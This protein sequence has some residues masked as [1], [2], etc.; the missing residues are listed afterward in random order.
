M[1]A[2]SPSLMFVV[3][4]LAIGL[5]LPTAAL[6][7]CDTL[8]GPVVTA[9]RKALENG[10]AKPVLIWPATEGPARGDSHGATGVAPHAD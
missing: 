8:D 5:G 2:S 4:G 9:A 6:A 1:N 7:H 3:L 10:D